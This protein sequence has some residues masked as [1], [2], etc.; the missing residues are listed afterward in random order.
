[1]CH[2]QAFGACLHASAR[3]TIS[4]RFRNPP[5]HQSTAHKEMDSTFF[6]GWWIGGSVGIRACW[7]WV[8][9][10]ARSSAAAAAAGAATVPPPPSPPTPP[11]ST[12]Q[13][14]RRRRHRSRSWRGSCSESSATVTCRARR[15]Y[16]RRDAQTDPSARPP[17]STHLVRWSR[18][19]FACSRRGDRHERYSR[20]RRMYA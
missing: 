11:P 6:I 7:R 16:L 8:T 4:S 15:A 20:S 9:T 10:R 5:I 19:A 12:A 1:V 3:H 13:L 2:G 14:S 17:R 18:R